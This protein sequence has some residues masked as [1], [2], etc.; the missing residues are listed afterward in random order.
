M[1]TSWAAASRWRHR[2]VPS[3][4]P[5]LGSQ[6]PKGSRLTQ[7][8]HEART[9]VCSG[10]PAAAGKEGRFLG[11]LR[12]LT[13]KAQTQEHPFHGP[14]RRPRAPKAHGFTRSHARVHFASTRAAAGGVTDTVPALTE[15]A[16]R[17]E[18]KQFGTQTSAKDHEG[19]SGEQVK[20]EA[21][22][23]SPG[24]MPGAGGAQSAHVPSTLG[25]L[26]CSDSAPSS[27]ATSG[28]HEHR[29][30]SSPSCRPRGQRGLLHLRHDDKEHDLAGDLQ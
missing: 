6:P 19:C 13:E 7:S 8:S 24:E 28:L 15:L 23:Q 22:A 14:Q 4:Q 21:G 12:A 5:A 20:A 30:G 1:G 25:V 11:W 29:V 26:V 3:S 16:V 17:R 2:H 9:R 27:P 10:H 18:E